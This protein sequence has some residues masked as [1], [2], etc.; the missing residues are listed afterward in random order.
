MYQ[1]KLK[2]IKKLINNAQEDEELR[3]LLG[4]LVSAEYFSY[5]TPSDANW[6]YMVGV[7]KIDGEIYEIV[8]AFGSIVGARK[9]FL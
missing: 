6:S 3:K 1:N 7:A 8:T 5:Y 9:L 2:H 4:K